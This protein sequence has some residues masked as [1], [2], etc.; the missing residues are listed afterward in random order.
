MAYG[1]LIPLGLGV[2]LFFFAEDLIHI[3]HFGP[4]TDESR[5]SETGGMAFRGFGLLLIAVG[6]TKFFESLPW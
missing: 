6:V 5:S 2:I 1:Y 4:V 3:R